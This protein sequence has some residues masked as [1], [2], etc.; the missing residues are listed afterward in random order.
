MRGA[1]S[2]QPREFKG[3]RLRCLIA[4]S[5]PELE[6]ASFL[7]ALVQPYA[8]VGVP[9]FW[10][11][12]GL[13]DGDEVRLGETMQ[14]LTTDH[15]EQLTDWW[16][17][18]RRRANTP[19]WDIVSTCRVGAATG[20]VLVE[21]KAHS[22]ELHRDGKAPGN[23]RNDERIREAISEANSALGGPRAGWRLSSTTHY[24]L[25]NRFAW[26]WKVASFGVPVILVYLGFLQAAE[27]DGGFSDHA[28]WRD[29][30]TEHA[31]D[32]VPQDVWDRRRPAGSSWFVPTIRSARITAAV[33]R[34]DA[35]S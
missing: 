25:C 29:C 16:L 9:D 5:L 14:F 32:V 23:L 26:A 4:T 17:A 6:V 24:Q 33:E 21:A 35:E 31:G 1:I 18:E 8:E 7:N 12:R 19:N 11:P 22:A 27:M 10:Q 20:L 13:L 30:L 28:A 34:S 2:F 15:R 3:S